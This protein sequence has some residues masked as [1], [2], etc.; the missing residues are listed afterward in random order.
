MNN[1]SYARYV[2]S[3]FPGSLLTVKYRH[4]FLISVGM[5]RIPASCS[6]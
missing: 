6:C 1:S 2:V 3:G 4:A 5:L